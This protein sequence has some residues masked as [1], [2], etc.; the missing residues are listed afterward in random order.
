MQRLFSMFPAGAAG[1]ALVMLRFSAAVALLAHGTEQPFFGRS[2]IPV[3]LVLPAGALCL[4]LLTP[5][6]AAMSCLIEVAVIFRFTG[7]PLLSLLLSIVNAAA[8]AMLGPGAYSLDALIF[9]RRVVR[10]CASNK[11]EPS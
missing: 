7:R 5:Y 11:S 4:G 3:A 10:F 6:T 9:G 1:I 8:L 2:F